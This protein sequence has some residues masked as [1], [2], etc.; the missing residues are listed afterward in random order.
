MDNKKNKGRKILEYLTDIYIFLIVII[1]PLIVDKT[2][3]FS[4]LECKWKSYVAITVLYIF[5]VVVINLY[6]LFHKI[7]LLDIKKSIINI[8]GIIFLLINILSCFLSPFFKDYNLFIGVGRGEGLIISSLYILSFLFIANFGKFK[9]KHILYFAISSI[10][11]SFVAIL[12]Y[13]GF[14]P[15]NM[16]QDGIGTH[17]VSFMATIGNIDFISAYYTITLSISAMAL[18]F[19]DNTKYEKIIY[20]VAIL[21]GSFIFP[22]IDVSS[23]KVAFLGIFILFLPFILKNN[24]RLAVF[25]KIVSVILLSIAICMFINVEYHYDLGK[26]GLYFKV[27]YLLLL[28]IFEILFLYFLSEFLNKI[29]FEI[30]D[31]KFSKRYYLCVTLLGIIFIGFLYLVPFKNGILYEV[32]EL[33]HFNLDDSFGT[34]RIFLWKRTLPLIKDY[35]L[36]GS[37][38]D[39]FALRFMPVYNDDVAALGPLTIND[40]A[41][42]IYLTMII[43]IGIIGTLIYIAFLGFNIYYGI[44]KVSDYSITLLSSIICYMIGSFFNLSVVVISPLFWTLLGIHYICINNDS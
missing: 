19:L 15:F 3:F 10:L 18:I 38:P 16:Y 44:K 21:F 36:L 33:L 7:K 39:T 29:N 11:V 4:I 2:G 41:A 31:K 20:Y 14:N 42:N 9:K 30:K 37:G 17:N 28:F 24:K 43:N 23:G 27:D 25:T 12:Q 8:L 32:H 6:Y 5:F 40:T 26:I 35:P 34:Y 1:F 13:V 22:I